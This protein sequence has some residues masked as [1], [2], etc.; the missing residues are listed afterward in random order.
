MNMTMQQPL[1]YPFHMTNPRLPWSSV[2]YHLSSPYRQPVSSSLS[3]F[4]L[5]QPRIPGALPPSASFS[6]TRYHHLKQSTSY[7]N[8]RSAHRSYD[9]PTRVHQHRPSKTKS[10]S[11]LQQLS[12]VN[13]THLPK[14]HSWHTMSHP[15]LNLSVAFANEKQLTP[16]RHRKHSPQKRKKQ[17]HP[18][19]RLPSS[20][21]R[22]PSFRNHRRPPIKIPECGV[23]RISTLDEMPINNK[24]KSQQNNT[25]SKDRLSTKGSISNSSKHRTKSKENHVDSDGQSSS[26]SNHSHSSLQQRLNGSLRNDPL[27]IAAMEN[28]RQFRRTSSQTKLST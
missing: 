28:F 25:I 9:V 17:I 15:Q 2:P 22:Q 4:I 10:V 11:D 26:S 12:R 23:V 5:S 21:K 14:A 16:K 1:S 3:P 27:I 7:P 13:S 19:R 20:P 8:R 24:Q 18:P 6:N